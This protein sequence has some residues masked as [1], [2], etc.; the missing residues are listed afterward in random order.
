MATHSSVLAWK[1]PGTGEPGGLLSLGLHRVGHNW[2]D[3]AAAAAAA[4]QS[5]QGPL[6]LTFLTLP[7]VPTQADYRV[8][9][10]ISTSRWPLT[11][12]A[13]RVKTKSIPSSINLELVGTLLSSRTLQIVSHT[14]QFYLLWVSQTQAFSC[15][16]KS[17]PLLWCPMCST[18]FH[19]LHSLPHL[20]SSQSS[21]HPPLVFQSQTP[22]CYCFMMFDS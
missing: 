3:L 1:I 5:H 11:P 17:L 4:T 16:Q 15:F 21:G 20:C 10:T 12:I 18:F 6:Q 13:L 19:S 7:Y 2:S 14:P 8:A 9:Y 22:C